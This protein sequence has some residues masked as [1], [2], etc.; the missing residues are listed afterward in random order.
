MSIPSSFRIAL[1][2]FDLGAGFSEARE[3]VWKILAPEMDSIVEQYVDK[4]ARAAPYYRKTLLENRDRHR[5]LIATYTQRLFLN[6]FDEHWV[7]D[8][9]ERVSAEIEL[10]Y[11]MRA[12]GVMAQTILTALNLSL[13]NRHPYSGRKA[14]RISDIAARVLM[15]DVINAAAF[16]QNAMVREARTYAVELD[17]AISRFDQSITSIRRSFTDSVASLTDM[18]KRLTELANGAAAHSAKG[19]MAANSAASDAQRTANSTDKLSGSIR[20]IHQQATS[21]AEKARNAASSAAGMKSAID[22]LLDCIGAIRSFSAMISGIA[23]QTNLLALNAS[24][25]AASAGEKGKGFAVVATEVKSLASQTFSATNHINEQIQI[26]DG[27]ITNSLRAIN[28]THAMIGDISSI[29]QSLESAVTEQ[30]RATNV[31]AQSVGNAAANANASAQA[32]DTLAA[33]AKSASDIAQFVSNFTR[34]LSAHMS[35]MNAAMDTLLQAW[36]RQSRLQKFADLGNA[37]T[38]DNEIVENSRRAI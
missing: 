11:D 27:A 35:E 34:E 13:A 23:S 30:T 2:S 25:E 17:E 37:A 10:G 36:I 28:E 26:I 4:T 20:E 22:V 32:L 16:H 38:E 15:L 21:S 1:E 3:E 5:K 14:A 29:S 18:S 8:T 24:I 12:R 7:T 33:E 6:A 19:A 31:I 9:K